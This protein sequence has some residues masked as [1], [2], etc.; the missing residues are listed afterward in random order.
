MQ[1]TLIYIILVLIYIFSI[2]IGINTINTKKDDLNNQKNIVLYYKENKEDYKGILEINKINLKRIFYDINSINNNVS[3]NI[4]LIKED[5]NIIILASHSGNN[6]NAYFN[7]LNKLIIGDEIKININKKEE[8][9]KLDNKY[10]E[11]KDGNLS[12]K[13]NDYKKT[14]VLITCNKINRQYQTVYIAYKI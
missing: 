14:L 10:D 7:N 12:I 13:Y 3:K 2:N 11:L 5:K 1:K 6:T 4:K 8:I 9:Y